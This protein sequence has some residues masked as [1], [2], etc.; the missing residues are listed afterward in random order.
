M[1]CV[2]NTI[3]R[4]HNFRS[5]ATPASARQD[6]SKLISELENPSPDDDSFVWLSETFF[7]PP[8]LK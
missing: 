2:N 6:V 5:L 4:I 7:G 1:V 3:K 8:G